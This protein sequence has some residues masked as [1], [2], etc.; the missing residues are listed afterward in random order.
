MRQRWS[1]VSD[2]KSTLDLWKNDDFPRFRFAIIT[3]S[4]S[5]MVGSIYATVSNTLK[6]EESETWTPIAHG[7][8]TKRKR[9]FSFY[10]P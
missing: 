5:L 4:K 6:N 8:V 7:F 9:E 10:F 3:S 1:V 2:K